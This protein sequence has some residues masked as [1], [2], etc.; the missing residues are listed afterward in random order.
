MVSKYTLNLLV[1]MQVDSELLVTIET[2]LFYV[3]LIQFLGVWFKEKEKKNKL[4]HKYNK[5]NAQA[6]PPLHYGLQLHLCRISAI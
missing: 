3:C 5:T 2:K 1:V 4:H 6:I